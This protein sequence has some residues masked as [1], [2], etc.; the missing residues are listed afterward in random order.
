MRDERRVAETTPRRRASDP[1]PRRRD[2]DFDDSGED[3]GQAA[4][5]SERS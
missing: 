1:Y 4:S 5:A 2:E 3:S